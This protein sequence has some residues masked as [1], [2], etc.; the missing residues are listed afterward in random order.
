MKKIFSKELIIGGCVILSLA[1]IFFG[2][3]YLKGI[4]V[5]KAA[6]YYYVSYTDV[7]GLAQSAPVTADG[8]KVGLVREISYEYDNPGHILVELS[9]D[10]ELKVPKGTKAVL[11]TDMLGTST[12]SLEMPHHADYHDVGDKLIGVNSTGMMDNISNE[13]L[14]SVIKM[15]PKIDSILVSINAIV[16]DP[17]LTQSVQRL[18]GIMANVESSTAAL[19]TTM[20]SIAP[21]SRQIPGIMN[22]V[23]Q[24]SASLNAVAADLSSLSARLKTMPIDSTMQNINEITANLNR[25]TATLNGTNSSVGLLLNDPALYNN[26][27]NTAAH[28]DSIMIDLKRQPKRYIP[29]IKIF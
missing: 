1:I 24:L 23:D 16:G 3:D 4:N 15:L 18:D 22:N 2:I 27:N 13:M 29:S 12:I 21:A 8:F 28:L 10:K 5:F 17:A 26:L 9:L 6:N 20:N 25:L 19:S 11:T 14:P 7:A